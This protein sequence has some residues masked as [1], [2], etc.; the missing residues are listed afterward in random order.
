MTKKK[1]KARDGEPLRLPKGVLGDLDP[2]AVLKRENESL[3]ESRTEILRK[4]REV[5]RERGREGR[6]KRQMIDV[7]AMERA[8]RAYN[9]LTK[10]GESV[11]PEP[12]RAEIAERS[13]LSEHT[14]KNLRRKH[15]TAHAVALRK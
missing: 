13:G 11:P 9:E 6:Q 15:I 10:N 8:A 2:L 4:N 3:R 7:P 5:P 14:I 1:R 12:S